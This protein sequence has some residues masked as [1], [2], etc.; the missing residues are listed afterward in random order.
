MP[1]TPQAAQSPALCSGTSIRERLIFLYN[2][3]CESLSVAL[4]I[5]LPNSV[6]VM[7]VKS[8]LQN[9]LSTLRLFKAP[10]EKDLRK[11]ESAQNDG[12]DKDIPKTSPSR[13]T[14]SA[15][16]RVPEQAINDPIKA[17]VPLSLWERAYET[18]RTQDGRL[19]DKYEKLLSAELLDISAYRIKV[20]YRATNISIGSSSSASESNSINREEQ[21]LDKIDNLIGDGNIQGH[22]AQLDAIAQRALQRMEAKNVQWTIGGHTIDLQDQVAQAATLV[23][24]L[25]PV[26]DEAVK[27]SPEA[28]LIWAGVCIVL[29]LLTSSSAA[30]EANR[31]GFTYVTARM[32]FYVALEPLILPTHPSPSA[33]IPPDLRGALEADVIDLYQH[34][35]EFQIR[36]VLRFCRSR[37]KN[38]GTDLFGSKKWEE[39]RLKIE[40]LEATL[41]RDLKG[42]NDGKSLAVLEVV[43]EKAKISCDIME[44]SLSV[45]EQHIRVSEEIRDMLSKLLYAIRRLLTP[46]RHI[47]NL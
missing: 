35:L 13:S 45:A 37:L 11:P 24:Y 40:K 25:K 18:L 2:I 42:V 7:P 20:M 28:S 30:R 12:S 26:I 32:R 41:D 34:I 31:D 46:R 3:H 15:G 5:L 4:T 38:Y 22:R 10:D 16:M 14:P 8:V 9:S 21:T 19:V 1:Y 39:M 47:P 33:A 29:P 17:S 23:G 27:A 36:S 44:K 6:Q 43:S